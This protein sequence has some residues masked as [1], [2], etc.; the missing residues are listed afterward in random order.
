MIDFRLLSR[1]CRWSLVVLLVCCYVTATS[2]ICIV[3]ND[4]VTFAREVTYLSRFVCLSVCNRD[5]S[6]RLWISFR[7]IYGK[8][9]LW[10]RNSTLDFGGDPGANVDAIPNMD[11]YRYFFVFRVFVICQIALIFYYFRCY[12]L[13]TSPI[14]ILC[15]SW[16]FTCNEQD[17]TYTSY[18]LLEL[19]KCFLVFISCVYI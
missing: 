7:E 3:D 19:C 18:W 16:Q 9:S 5:F 11:P 1:S 15:V 12:H 8:L 10:A 14:S 2:G 6:K 13:T 4:I 17:K